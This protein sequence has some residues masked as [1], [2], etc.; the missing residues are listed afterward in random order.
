MEVV[1]INIRWI[2]EDIGKGVMIYVWMFF[3]L[4]EDVVEYGCGRG[5]KFGR[6]EK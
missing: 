5:F 1:F 3:G 2:G 6:L 4:I